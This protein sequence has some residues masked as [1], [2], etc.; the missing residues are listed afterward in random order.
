M[1]NL[2][3]IYFFLILILFKRT[4]GHTEAIINEPILPTNIDDFPVKNYHKSNYKLT[5][6]R[7]H[8]QEEYKNRKIYK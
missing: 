5:H 3:E 1:S 4:I 2:F 6:P 8:F 7:Y